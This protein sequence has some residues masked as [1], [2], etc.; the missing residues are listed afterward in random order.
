MLELFRKASVLHPWRH[1]RVQPCAWRGS[2]ALLQLW[3]TRT[4]IWSR[5]L[6]RAP[7][8]S[9]CGLSCFQTRMKSLFGSCS[10]TK[11]SN[12][13]L[14]CRACMATKWPRSM[15]KFNRSSLARIC[16]PNMP[17]STGI[18]WGWHGLLLT[19][20]SCPVLPPTWR[21]T[22]DLPKIQLKPWTSWSRTMAS[23]TLLPTSL[24]WMSLLARLQLK[25]RVCSRGLVFS[26]F[27]LT[28]TKTFLMVME[29]ESVVCLSWAGCGIGSLTGFLSSTCAGRW[30]A[31]PAES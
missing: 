16:L 21:S 20:P 2:M 12:P 26:P 27:S 5:H 3:R 14:K 10:L 17:M 1:F 8:K 24:P 18:F 29:R 19:Y 23:T 6:R 31:R 15:P 11:T 28:G 25:S 9:L 7:V 4:R 13:K 30:L 22:A